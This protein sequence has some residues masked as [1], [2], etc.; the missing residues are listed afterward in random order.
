MS[1]AI[2][3]REVRIYRSARRQNMYLYVDA[4]EDLARVPEALLQQFGR[5]IQVMD[6]LLTPERRLARADAAV[7]LK[8]IDD[9]GFY[10]QMPPVAHEAL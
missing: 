10:L 4:A 6:L 7:V 2:A 1:G 3:S 9:A 5:Q 8:N